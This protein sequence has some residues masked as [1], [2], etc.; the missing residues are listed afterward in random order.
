MK[1]IIALL[2]FMLI[3]F[4]LKS[5]WNYSNP[6]ITNNG[7]YSSFFFNDLTGFISSN[8]VKKTTDG[9]ISWLV[10]NTSY[11]GLSIT[12][13]DQFTGFVSSTNGLIAKTTDE[14]ATWYIKNSAANASVEMV[15]FTSA[16][17]GYAVG[18]FY[19]SSGGF[20]FKTIN[21]G[22]N[23]NTVFSNAQ[24]IYSTSCTDNNTG[25]ICGSQ[26]RIYKTVNGGLNWSQLIT[27]TQSSLMDIKFTDQYTGYAVGGESTVLKTT[28]SG[29]NWVTKNAPGSNTLKKVF[30]INANTGFAVGDYI[31]GYLIK[32]TNGGTN[33]ESTNLM[34]GY[35][36]LSNV[37]FSSVNIGYLAGYPN[38]LK[39]TDGGNNWFY[40]SSVTNEHLQA[41]VFSDTSLGVAVGNNGMILRTSN[42]G[43]S[44][45]V[46]SPVNSNRLNNVTSVNNNTLL[47]AGNSG[48]IIISANSGLNWSIR[49]SPVN[50]DFY[51]SAFI[52]PNTGFI[53]GSNGVILKTINSGGNWVQQTSGT[54]LKLNCIRFLNSVTGFS[55]GENGLLIRT[56]DSGVTWN[57]VNLGVSNNLKSLFFI[58][59]SGFLAGSNG[60]L[61]KTTNSGN[62]WLT[63]STQAGGD[64]NS[65]YFSSLD[66]GVLA[67]SGGSVKVTSNGGVNWY[68][69]SIQNGS[70]N[71]SL[72]SVCLQ[73]NKK[74][75]IAGNYG[76]ILKANGFFSPIIGIQNNSSNL[77]SFSLSQNYPNP[78]NPVTNIK[79]NIPKS[80][81]VKITVFDMLGRE[82]TSIVNESMQPGS[83]NVDWDASNYS[84]GVYFYKLETE[85]FVESK[86]MVLLK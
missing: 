48:T 84:S 78:F 70:T 59:N 82:V 55:C 26:G 6:V 85:G 53:S 67:F 23:W 54:S 58:D 86:K 80:G 74:G 68:Q 63:Q 40:V 13:I 69:T 17:T 22:E 35:I 73:N 75:F 60:F 56:T 39:S 61:S 16:A 41:I 51:S 20:V 34:F 71:F 18:Y 44:W 77:Q 25:Y 15:Q 52:D 79:F 9:G 32:T 76:I 66:T 65:V 42:S 33:W 49:T 38:S 5:E 64:I 31:G 8:P 12:F 19:G 47:A 46:Q 28:N 1:Q 57:S 2:L 14:G 37:N 21:S 43:N 81:F 36:P 72:N 7:Y 10:Q 30:F 29:L 50:E 45:I 4:S 62:N 83:Y 3:T 11:G 27:N 24:N